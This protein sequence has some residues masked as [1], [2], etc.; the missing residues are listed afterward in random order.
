LAVKLGRALLADD[1]EFRVGNIG[2]TALALIALGRFRRQE[3]IGPPG[4]LVSERGG[5]HN[6]RLSGIHWFRAALEM[7]H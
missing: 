3:I 5:C 6:D 4:R 7:R 2:R 1:D